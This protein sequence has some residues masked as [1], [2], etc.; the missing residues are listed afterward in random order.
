[1]SAQLTFRQSDHYNGGREWFGYGGECHQHPR[2][3]LLT[4]SIRKTQSTEYEY[5]VDGE[6]VADLAS[7][8]ERIKSPPFV[9]D[10]E[11][12][13]LRSLSLEWSDRHAWKQWVGGYNL[14]HQLRRKGLIEAD[15]GRIRLS[16]L[17]V[18]MLGDE[19]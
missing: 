15:D 14:A 6:K 18:S 8:L 7:A 1:M 9:C 4:R 10:N 19:A 12:A 16:E 3:Y 5:S 11:R 2:I 13:A 17:G